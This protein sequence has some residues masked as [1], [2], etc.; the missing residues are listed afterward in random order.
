MPGSP[1]RALLGAVLTGLCASALLYFA[2]IF[3]SSFSSTPRT[4]LTSA[5]FSMAPSK[6]APEPAECAMKVEKFTPE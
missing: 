5:L 3:P 2:L 6:N 4:F 1:F